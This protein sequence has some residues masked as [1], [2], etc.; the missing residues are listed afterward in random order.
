M[1]FKGLF[2]N[3]FDMKLNT[4]FIFKTLFCSN[5]RG[6]EPTD[7]ITIYVGYGSRQL[8]NCVRRSDSLQRGL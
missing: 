4:Y 2:L 7:K 1:K 8:I 3:V 5:R 6:I